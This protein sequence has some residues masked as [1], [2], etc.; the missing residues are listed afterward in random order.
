MVSGQEV[1]SPTFKTAEIGKPLEFLYKQGDQKITAA[2]FADSFTASEAKRTERA[3]AQRRASP[4][5]PAAAPVPDESEVQAAITK[6]FRPT[7]KTVPRLKPAEFVEKLFRGESILSKDFE[8][9]FHPDKC[10]PDASVMPSYEHIEVEV[11]NLIF[12]RMVKDG[13][14]TR[15]DPRELNKVKAELIKLVDNVAA[16]C[17]APLTAPTQS[18]TKIPGDGWCF[19]KAIL[20]GKAAGNLEK[21]KIYTAND[22]IKSQANT[23]AYGLA[24][25]IATIILDDK[26]QLDNFKYL[27][28]DKLTTNVLDENETVTENVTLT[29]DQYLHEMQQSPTKH[30]GFPRVYGEG[31]PLLQAA[32]QATNKKIAIYDENGDL[33]AVGCPKPPTNDVISLKFVG[34][35]HFDV[36][37]PTQ[38]SAGRHKRRRKLRKSTFR[39]H[40]KH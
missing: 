11:C 28:G 23:R 1:Y 16:E 32:A 12:Q 5:P 38:Q 17:K 24:K 3:N 26:E 30:E 36:F 27:F 7:H 29:P 22:H 15:I 4:P 13:K 6:V 19:Y 39:R 10:A 2:I 35:N 18:P 31:I 34:G 25:E 9:T 14:T 37:L 21:A 20:A 40:R 8:L 33:R